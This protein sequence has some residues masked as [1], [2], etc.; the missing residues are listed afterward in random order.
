MAT[1]KG[2]S[3]HILNASSIRQHELLQRPAKPPQPTLMY[4]KYDIADSDKFDQARYLDVTSEL[5]VLLQ[6]LAHMESN[7]KSSIIISYLKDHSIQMNWLNGNNK[8]AR[9]I[10]SRSHDTSHI[11][12]LFDGCRNNKS[13]LRDFEAYI[14]TQVQTSH[15]I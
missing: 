8:L 10:T 2:N 15:Y 13:F 1:I 9:T 12:A 11:E 4:I 6:G 7:Y 14:T 5:H 3:L